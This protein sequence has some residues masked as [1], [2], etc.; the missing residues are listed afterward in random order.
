MSILRV[1]ILGW[2]AIGSAVAGRIVNGAVPGAKLTAVATRTAPNGVEV[3]LVTASELSDHCDIVIET[4]G[5]AA[6]REHVPTILRSGCRVIVVSTGALRDTALLE[7]LTLAGG[8]RLLLSTGAIGGVDIIRACQNIGE[9]HSLSLTTTKPP[10]VLIQPWMDPA[11]TD[12]LSSGEQRVLCFEGSALEVAERFPASV[13]VAATLALAAKS[14]YLIQVSVIGDPSAT[15]N[16]HVIDIDADAGRY[17][18]E[19]AN[20]ALESNPAS[21][22]L[23][24]ASILR[25]LET[26]ATTANPQFV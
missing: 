12:A 17:R 26:L 24:V 8:D 10:T 6:V 11:M 22:A 19:L 4:A 1:G 15:G 3:S 25:A 2:G 18:I 9:I 16:T 21:S 20:K 23:V 5:H 14:W 13:N 7:A